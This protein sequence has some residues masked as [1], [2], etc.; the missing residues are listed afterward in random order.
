M[1]PISVGQ[2][3]HSFLYTIIVVYSPDIVLLLVLDTP[4]C[5]VLNVGAIPCRLY[6][7][8]I[9]SLPFISRQP[10]IIILGS[11]FLPLPI[12]FKVEQTPLGEYTLRI[13]SIHSGLS[14]VPTSINLFN[15]P[16]S[17][18]VFTPAVA[19]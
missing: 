10:D 8:L 18:S 7:L 1:H 4:P 16:Q 2:P 13:D 6:T 9:C 3:I 12:P 14:S 11:V 19:E 5:I 17:E 15:S